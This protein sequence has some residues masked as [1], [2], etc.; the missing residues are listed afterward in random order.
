MLVIEGEKCVR[1]LVYLATPKYLSTRPSNS[2]ADLPVISAFSVRLH[3]ALYRRDL[4][5]LLLL[6]G[7]PYLAGM[8]PPSKY[9][10]N[11]FRCPEYRCL[12]QHGEPACSI[13]LLPFNR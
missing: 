10:V 7:Y 1:C 5:V 11:Y 9:V 12:S 2:V 4:A 3:L 6:R 8:P 13:L